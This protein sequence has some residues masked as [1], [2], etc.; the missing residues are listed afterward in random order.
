MATI[1]TQAGPNADHEEPSLDIKG[2]S[3]LWIIRWDEAFFSRV[4]WGFLDGKHLTVAL[5]AMAR[6]RMSPCSGLLLAAPS[7][8][9]SKLCRRVKSS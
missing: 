4:L 6:A 8:S 2:P 3:G 1:S 7:K 5:I 9:V